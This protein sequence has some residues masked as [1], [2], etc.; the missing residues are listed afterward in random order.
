M[1]TDYGQA[2]YRFRLFPDRYTPTPAGGN[3][4]SD[5]PPDLIPRNPTGVQPGS[6]AG[7]AGGAGGRYAEELRRNR[8]IQNLDPTLTPTEDFWIDEIVRRVSR[9]LQASLASKG[10][11]DAM[12]Y[13]DFTSIP[14]S[15]GAAD[16]AVLAQAT[17]KRVY[18]YLINTHATQRLFVTFGTTATVLLGVPL[19]ANLGFFE[20]LFTVPQNEVHLIANGAAT[21]GVLI[22]SELDPEALG[23]V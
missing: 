8:S 16:Q 22:Y 11:W 21:T 2:G 4:V 19:E 6:V 12:R 18:L 15:V 5:A 17:R 3:V 10:V 9:S 1:A 14:L 23:V 13:C 7:S 20:W